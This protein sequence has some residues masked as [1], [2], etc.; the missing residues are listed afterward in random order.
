MKLHDGPPLAL[1]APPQQLD[2]LAEHVHAVDD[3][4]LL[5]GHDD[6]DL[7][8]LR[9]VVLEVRGPL[10][11]GGRGGGV[12]VLE[13]G[14]AL[15]HVGAHQRGGVQKSAANGWFPQ[16]PTR[17]AGTRAPPSSSSAHTGRQ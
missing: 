10:G 15:Q 16:R 3:L 4:V 9:E 6:E 7:V 2:V 11:G 8:A 1:D 17:P 13:P 5:H 12:V 14:L